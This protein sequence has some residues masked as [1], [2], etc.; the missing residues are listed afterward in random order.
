[1]VGHR[2][3]GLGG[4][5]GLPPGGLQPATQDRVAA[6]G[7]GLGDRAERGTLDEGLDAPADARVAGVGVVPGG[8][9]AVAVLARGHLWLSGGAHGAG[10]AP[11]G[12]SEPSPAACPSWSTAAKLDGAFATV[13]CKS[14]SNG[15]PGARRR[16]VDIVE[17]LS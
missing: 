3:P 5:E 9:E 10:S 16:T 8:W 12:I 6:G 17:A 13:G 11:R 4:V 7:Q 2:A 1:M 15:Q 14:R